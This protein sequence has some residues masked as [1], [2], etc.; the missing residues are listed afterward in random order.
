MDFD[1]DALKII[2]EFLLHVLLCSGICIFIHIFFHK[3][4]HEDHEH[5]LDKKIKDTVNSLFK[6][7]KLSMGWLDNG[8]P[9]LMLN[10]R[11][12]WR[13]TSKKGTK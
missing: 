13:T 6:R 2:G 12:S 8:R 3:K 11:R 10:R 5:D 4:A 1:F 7:K 9:V